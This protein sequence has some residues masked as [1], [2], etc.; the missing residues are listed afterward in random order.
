MWYNVRMKE[1]PNLRRLY[2]DETQKTKILQLFLDKIDIN[3]FYCYKRFRNRFS[4]IEIKTCFVL[5][6]NRMLTKH[7]N[8]S[9][10]GYYGI[11]DLDE[12]TRQYLVEENS[13]RFG[14]KDIINLKIR[15]HNELAEKNQRPQVD[16]KAALANL[17]GTYSKKGGGPFYEQELD[18][19]LKRI[20]AYLNEAYGPKLM[21]DCIEHYVY[22]TTFQELVKDMP[23]RKRISRQAAHKH[24]RRAWEDMLV[25]FDL[26]PS[27]DLCEASMEA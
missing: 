20:K 21:K 1:L 4:D 2:K 6:V 22:G 12:L 9:S 24:L 18:L 16:L 27:T 26:K 8:K 15:N 17:T 10:S 5:A 13:F 23:K 11:S 7:T 19:M 25:H 3:S 14:I